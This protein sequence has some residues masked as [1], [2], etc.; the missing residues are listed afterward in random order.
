MGALALSAPVRALGQGPSTQALYSACPG[1]PSGRGLQ[2]SA[3]SA[4]N[5]PAAQALCR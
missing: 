2:E 1:Y 5:R 4:K 3:C